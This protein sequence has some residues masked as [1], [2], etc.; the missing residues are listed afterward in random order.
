ML[1]RSIACSLVSL[2]LSFAFAVP[3]SARQG[4]LDPG[5]GKKGQVSVMLGRT[6]S[7]VTLA[8]TAVQPD[9]KVIAL[10]STKRFGSSGYLR[11]SGRSEMIRFTRSGRIDMTFG[12]RGHV[13]NVLGGTGNEIP[14]GVAITSD[15]SIVVGGVVTGSTGSNGSPAIA[16]FGLDGKR[17]R[18]FGRGGVARFDFVRSPSATAT[19]IVSKVLPTSD[20]GI[21]VGGGFVDGSVASGGVAR[22]DSAGRLASS[23]GADGTAAIAPDPSSP[24]PQS[25]VKDLIPLANG[26]FVAV[27][28]SRIRLENAAYPSKGDRSTCLAARFSPAGIPVGAFGTGGQTNLHYP[29][30]GEYG[31]NSPDCVRGIQRSDG[32][33]LLLSRT[34]YAGSKPSTNDDPMLL[35]PDGQTVFDWPVGEDFTFPDV[36]WTIGYYEGYVSTFGF[37]RGPGESIYVGFD[38]ENTDG[39]R[40]RVGV[41]RLR[42]DGSRDKTFGRNGLG[43]ARNALGRCQPSTLHRGP[44]HTLVIGGISAWTGRKQAVTLCLARLEAK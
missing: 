23:F 9:G 28:S 6:D 38:Y 21:L 22:L 27:G 44:S 19:Q 4:D 5:F 43:L 26:E 8:G 10:L 16:K 25:Y 37:V 14:N 41:V 18:T 3:A 30:R 36:P 15:R 17:V 24:T 2:T 31:A 39:Y 7:E 13:R 12:S 35:S 33:L 1:A 20:G 11:E 29:Y 42:A 40:E 34:F 32:R